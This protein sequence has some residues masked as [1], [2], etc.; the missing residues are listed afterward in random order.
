MI[1]KKFIKLFNH[2]VRDPQKDEITQF[3]ADIAASLQKITELSV[4]K[5]IKYAVKKYNNSNICLAGGVALNCVAN[6]KLN[7]LDTVNELWVQPAAGDAGAALGAAQAFWHHEL[8]MERQTS[9]EDKMGGGYLGPSYGNEHIELELKDLGAN[10]SFMETNLLL[11][12]VAK[13]ISD[14]KYVGWLQGRMEFGP[15]AL[16]ARSIL[17]DPRRSETQVDLN[18]KVKFRE[19]FRPF[20]PAILRSKLSDWYVNDRDSNYM[21]VVDKIKAEHQLKQTYK[22]PDRSF[23]DKLKI[24][25]S[26]VPAVT[27]IDF[28]SRIQTVDGK[29]NSLFRDLIEEF[30]KL[31]N[32]PMLVNTSFNVNNEPIVC[33]V[34]DAYRCFMKTDIDVLVCGNFL[35]K[36]EDQN[37]E[38]FS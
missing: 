15:R 37:I 2:P 3:H 26:S 30:Y 24:P 8:G 17:A 19:S 11:H 4:C 12:N 28:T 14:G 16:G 1:N 13:M 38:E 20:A 9:N 7:D 27:H 22:S 35:L 32:V 5:I 29:Y 34:S 36:K 10:F 33:T 6:S 31:T 25:N 21:L 23:V 18:L